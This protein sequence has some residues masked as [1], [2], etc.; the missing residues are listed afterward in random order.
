MR[1]CAIALLLCCGAAQAQVDTCGGGIQVSSFKLTGDKA[2]L[3]VRA[4]SRPTNALSEILWVDVVPDCE[5]ET[6]PRI[7]GCVFGDAARHDGSLIFSTCTKFPWM[8]EDRGDRIRLTPN[9]FEHAIFDNGGDC[10]V[11]VILDYEFPT[12]DVTPNILES[13]GR[14]VGSCGQ[15]NWSGGAWG[16]FRNGLGSFLKGD[17]PVDMDHVEDG[18]REI[19]RR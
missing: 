11:G 7:G 1:K 2:I 5:R 4:I 8:I 18:V 14:L 15:L 12:A 3:L 9:P 13:E 10:T 16:A 6:V 19:E 17:A